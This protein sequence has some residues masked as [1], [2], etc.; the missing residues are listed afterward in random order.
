[1][2]RKL[3]LA[4]CLLLTACQSTPSIAPLPAWQAPAQREHALTGQ[5][6][7]LRS[8]QR[9]TPAQLLARL[10]S[11]ER[12]LI[13]EKH[14]N[15]D[16]HALQRWLLRGLSEHSVLLEMLEPTQQAQVSATQQQVQAGH[17]PQ[18]LP[19]ALGWSRGWDWQQYGPLLMALLP[20]PPAVLAANLDRAEMTAI[21]RNPPAL[22][23][24]ASTA[25]AVQD[26][27]REQI[28]RSHCGMLPESKLPAMLAIQQQRDRRMA[29]R[30]LAAPAPAV[31]LAGSYHAR[32]DLGV[33][34]H[35]QDLGDE[36]LV[37]LLAEA[38]EPVAAGEADLV[39]YT[40]A[41]APE[42]YC[43]QLRGR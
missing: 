10:G 8:G 29:E 1:M 9:L 23:G 17:W 21:Y 35:V 20:Q 5:I 40:P 19:Q 18:D 4:A 25:Q 39:W 27:L 37:L 26:A 36:S 30:L 32:R 43:A 28:R 16:H 14:D 13:G 3:L 11:A 34:L 24:S 2:P 7:D 33:P 41:T 31:L 12:I 6:I 22:T 15:P 42:D 38:G